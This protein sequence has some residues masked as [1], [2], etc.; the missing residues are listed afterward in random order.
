M[1]SLTDY[2]IDR[3]YREL[4]S[5]ANPYLGLIAS[6]F[7]RQAALI[8]SCMNVGSIHGMMNTN[9]MAISDETIDYGDIPQQALRLKIFA[10]GRI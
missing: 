3:P 2:L 7:D 4:K 5:R 10:H 8:A 6:V 9:N 1:R